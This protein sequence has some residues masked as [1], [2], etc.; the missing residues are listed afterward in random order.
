MKDKNCIF[1]KIVAEQIPAT[2]R[3]FTVD[4]EV[5]G[6]IRPRGGGA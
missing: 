4:V 6:E 2:F 3:G 5:M 1:C